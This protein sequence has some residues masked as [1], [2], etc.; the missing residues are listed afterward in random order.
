MTEFHS[1]LV[2]GRD[3]FLP[4][5]IRSDDFPVLLSQNPLVNRRKEV[6]SSTDFEIMKRYFADSTSQPKV[7]G[8][9]ESIKFIEDIPAHDAE[10]GH[11]NSFLKPSQ[12]MSSM[13]YSDYSA[14]SRLEP[15]VVKECGMCRSR[16]V[17]NHV[18]YGGV[19]ICL[20]CCTYW[21]DF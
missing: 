6:M 21:L 4:K 2:D 8:L 7:K 15:P 16:Y 12:T 19:N 9:E 5:L 11:N 18:S 3:R 10:I 14:P 20:D 13:I 1:K 17:S